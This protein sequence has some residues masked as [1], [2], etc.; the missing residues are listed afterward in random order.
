[1][2]KITLI[3]AE[4]IDYGKQLRREGKRDEALEYIRETT[5]VLKEF[6]SYL[7]AR[8]YWRLLGLPPN[9]TY[10][11]SGWGIYKMRRGEQA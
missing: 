7:D 4:D 11:D 9:A 6:D 2:Y 3:Y 1:M 10:H 8:Q 5:D